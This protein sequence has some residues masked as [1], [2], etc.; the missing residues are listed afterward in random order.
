MAANEGLEIGVCPRL[1]FIGTYMNK[2]RNVL[3]IVL[4]ICFSC[5]YAS[6]RFFVTTIPTSCA[7]VNV[8][9]TPRMCARIV[10]ELSKCLTF[11]PPSDIKAR[12]FRVRADCYS[13]LDQHNLALE[14]Q[15]RA[16]EILTP[17]YVW[18]LLMLGAFYRD[19]KEYDLSL[20][21]L[22]QALKIS[23]SGLG[24]QPT[25][26]EYYHLGLT[27]NA[28]G[29][30]NEAID[31]FTKGIP[32]QRNYGYALYHRALAYEGIGNKKLAKNDLLQAKK[33]A[34]KDGYEEFVLN[35]FREYE[36]FDELEKNQQEE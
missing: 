10:E 15:S 31:A 29:R 12:V 3:F 26:P 27:L 22:K 35:K 14:D 21:V 36:I 11:S 6:D 30:Y 28:A 25:M 18:A 16:L 17:D 2:L 23:E 24:T 33:L 9:T 19:M 8:E 20:A 32:K 4:C 13:T 5:S 7:F 1:L 34:P